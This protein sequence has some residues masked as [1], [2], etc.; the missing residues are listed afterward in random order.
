MYECKKCNYQTQILFNF[1]RHLKR[2]YPCDRKNTIV[3]EVDNRTI[4]GESEDSNSLSK[5]SNS[6]SNVSNSLSKESISLL[7]DPIV[8]NEYKCSKCSKVLSCS[9]TLKKHFEKCKGVLSTQCPV[10]L[11][12]FKNR[13]NK[14][15]HVH[16][17]S[18]QPPT[19]N[20]IN[21]EPSNVTVF[22]EEN[23]DYL[24]DDANI[25]QRLKKYS[26]KGV[27]GLADIVEEIYCNKEQP[28]NNTIIKPLDY[29]DGVF[30]KEDDSKW[31]FRE[32]SDIR[33]TL[34]DSITKYV[35]MYNVVKNKKNIKLSDCKEKALINK[36]SYILLALDGDIPYDLYNEL[37]I[38]EK[39]FAELYDKHDYIKESWRK[40]DKATM[41]K[42][43]DFSSKHVKKEKGEYILT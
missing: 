20:E 28:Q 17:Q 22:G 16:H 10:C 2:K 19:S 27:Y 24:L 4:D 33:S 35:K 3:H 41:I 32:F 21:A 7:N 39:T 43:Y 29:G 40:F 30:I 38:K 14:Y 25:L 8:K 1:E 13:K 9:A 37:E 26:K 34:I 31:E 42:L 6:L 11:K 23:L 5:G 18:C 36:W 12:V 15:Y